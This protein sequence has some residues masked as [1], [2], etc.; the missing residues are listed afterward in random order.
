MFLLIIVSPSRQEVKKIQ[1]LMEPF[2][3]YGLD[4]LEK[5]EVTLDPLQSFPRI[6]SCL[7]SFF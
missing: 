6:F 4:I 1:R 3:F 7:P 2:H 5:E